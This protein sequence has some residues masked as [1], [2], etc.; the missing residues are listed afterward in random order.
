V[1]ETRANR[2]HCWEQAGRRRGYLPLTRSSHIPFHDPAPQGSGAAGRETAGYRGEPNPWSRED[3]FLGPT[4]LDGPRSGAKEP[5]KETA[6]RSAEP[7][8]VGPDELGAWGPGG[9]R[10]A[11]RSLGTSAA[12][13]NSLVVTNS[14]EPRVGA[15]R[16]EWTRMGQHQPNR[17]ASNKFQDRDEARRSGPA[18]TVSHK[19]SACA[20]H[21]GARSI[22]PGTDKSFHRT[23]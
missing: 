1:D 7:A 4:S 15:R 11:L 3:P 13:D 20:N 16:K 12:K 5:P 14:L 9:A 19:T 10:P 8:P 23:D 18:G 2:D 17:N 6:R 21:A 22:R